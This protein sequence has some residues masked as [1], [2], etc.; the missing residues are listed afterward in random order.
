MARRAG[1]VAFFTLAS[2]ILGYGRDA[3]MANIF[4]AG[5]ALDA[6]VV[7][8]TI[9]N[10]LRRL[11]AEGSLMIAFVPLLSAEKAAGGLPAMR[12]FTAAVLGILIPVLLLFTGLGMLFPDVAVSLFAAGFDEPR[13][14]LAAKLTEIMMSFLFFVSLTALAGGALN[15]VGVFAAPAAAPILL[16]VAI[17]AASLLARRF[18][19][20]PIEAVAWGL[21]AGGVLQ[22]LLQLPFLAKRGLLVAP[23]W[24]PRHP[25][26]VQLLKRMLP[27]VFGVAVYQLNLIVIRQIASFLPGGQLSC[28]FW[29]T[30][31]EEFALGVFAVSI[32]IAALP[33]LSEHAARGDLRALFATF[34]RALKTTNFITIPAAVGLFV[35]AT[36]VVGVLFRHGRFTAED[37][38]LTAELVRIMALALVPIGAVRVIVPTYYA[39][40]DTK[41][42]VAAAS[43]SLV[44]TAVFG[45]LLRDR[46]EIQGL[47]WATLLGAGAQLAV[48]ALY[49][50]RQAAAAMERAAA[51][52]GEAPRGQPA[53]PPGPADPHSVGSH[54][55][56]CLLAIAPGAA[57]AFVAAGSRSWFGGDNLVG[58]AYLAAIMG[59][60]VAS[61]FVVSRWLGL[62]EGELVLGALRRRLL[63][64][65]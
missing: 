23:R 35:L 44:A 3:V 6:F 17:I 25:P 16:N 56:R 12:R 27:A 41:T 37:A 8:Q 13:A 46:F 61:Y 2:R 5:V 30:R 49:L 47:T 51:A 64:R 32:G 45:W 20:V 40:G 18:F 63:R 7:A 36:P 28:Y 62:P 31:L 54:A 38:A 59:P 53:P 65:R 55:V 1:V 50:R 57:G 15:T 52:T 29:A 11:V 34:R 4:G 58:L 60:V 14:E 43:A 33:T 10:L 39:V 24:E 42:P 48:L 21:V 22:L 26:V 19:E 9:P